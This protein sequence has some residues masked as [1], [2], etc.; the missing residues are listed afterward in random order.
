MLPL[1]PEFAASNS[2]LTGIIILNPAVLLIL[3]GPTNIVPAIKLPTAISDPPML[4]LEARYELIARCVGTM[5]LESAVNNGSVENSLT[6]APVPPTLIPPNLSS[7]NPPRSKKSELMV[8]IPVAC[9]T[10]N[11]S[12]VL[13]LPL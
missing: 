1:I 13:K 10:A 6:T 7:D 12:P 9:S 2:A 11:S 5:L 3:S 8:T 4:S